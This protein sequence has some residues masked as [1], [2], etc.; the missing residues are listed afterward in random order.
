MDAHG[1]HFVIMV[2]GMNK[3]M[4]SLI[5]EVRGSFENKWVQYRAHA[6]TE[7]RDRFSANQSR[8]S[9]FTC[10]KMVVDRMRDDVKTEALAAGE[11]C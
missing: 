8:R 11:C 10:K 7:R 6:K 1:Y 2:K 5:Q 4:N 9:D 3:L